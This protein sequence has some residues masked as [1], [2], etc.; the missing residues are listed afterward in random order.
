ME[1]KHYELQIACR[2]R[3]HNL[4]EPLLKDGASVNYGLKGACE[5]GHK[6][7]AEMMINKGA[8]CWNFAL[9]GACEYGHIEMAQMIIDKGGDKIVVHNGVI[10]DGWAWAFEI[11]CDKGY[12]E[13]VHMMIKY[14]S[15]YWNSKGIV[16]T[17]SV[18]DAGLC[19]TCKCGHVELTQQL[20][21]MGANDWSK[22]LRYACEGGQTELALQ[23][24]ERGANPSAGLIGS[25]KGNNAKLAQLMIELGAKNFNDGLKEACDRYHLRIVQLM[26][27]NGANDWEWVLMRFKTYTAFIL[28]ILLCLKR[29]RGFVAKIKQKVEPQTFEYFVNRHGI[30]KAHLLKSSSSKKNLMRNVAQQLVCND[31]ATFVTRFVELRGIQF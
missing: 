21:E 23:M 15:V 26:I 1:N 31:V 13:L 30:H 16:Y 17:K 3:N 24:I 7:I 10:T 25:C 6:D 14:G 9:W 4:I 19:I 27:N 2:K 12:T 22:A 29:C 18:Y 8:V 11:A 28:K 20:I 5:G